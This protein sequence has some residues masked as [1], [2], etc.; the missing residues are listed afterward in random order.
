VS[1]Y[2]RVRGTNIDDA[3]PVVS[4]YS[5]GLTG[6]GSTMP[7]YADGLE[8]S[9]DATRGRKTSLILTELAGQSATVN[10]RLYEPGSRT[11]AVA[12]KDFTISANGEL[13][14]DNLFV[15]MGLESSPD[16]LDQRKKNQINVAA[17]VTATGG[18]GV[19]TAQAVM[20]DNKTGDRR[21]IA[22]VPAGGVPA[23]T[24]QRSPTTSAPWRRR[25]VGK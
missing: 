13:R 1:L 14:L 11:A 25:A 19:I 4:V 22:F 17:V 23:T 2:A 15:S 18:I 6:G 24:P 3:L 9:I 5:E 7:L 16:D 10:V 20:T 12:E 8:H 21:T